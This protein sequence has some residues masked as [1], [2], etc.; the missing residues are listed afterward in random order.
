MGLTGDEQDQ[1]GNQD[2]FGGFSGFWG[3][4]GGP[5]GGAGQGGSA[6]FEEIFADFESFFDMGRG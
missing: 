6:P 1:A 5:A 4:R 3:G 2:P